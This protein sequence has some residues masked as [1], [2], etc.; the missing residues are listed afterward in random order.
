MRQQ[1]SAAVQELAQLWDWQHKRA[2][3]GLPLEPSAEEQQVKA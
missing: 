1:R 3:E 2:A